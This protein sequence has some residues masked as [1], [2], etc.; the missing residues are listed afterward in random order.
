MSGQTWHGI[1]RESECVETL[2]RLGTAALPD[3]KSGTHLVSKCQVQTRLSQG[4]AF[5]RWFHVL[6]GL[7][8]LG[9]TLRRPQG[10]PVAG[11]RTE[12]VVTTPEGRRFVTPKPISERE[13]C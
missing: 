6:F 12:L 4:L 8:R 11:R 2:G 7:T 10:V 1:A 3:P 5:D 13:T 9:L